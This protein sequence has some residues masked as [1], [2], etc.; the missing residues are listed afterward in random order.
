MGPTLQLGRSTCTIVWYATAKCDTYVLYGCLLCTCTVP[1]GQALIVAGMATLISILLGRDL[2]PAHMLVL[3]ASAM[4]SAAIASAVLGSVMIMVILVSH[5]LRINPDNVATPI[6][7]SLG[8]LVTLGLLSL[9]AQGLY[10][11]SGELRAVPC[12]S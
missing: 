10:H 8:D 4:G 12:L 2:S 7:A 11:L 5:R 6:A 3:A 1:Q 9:I